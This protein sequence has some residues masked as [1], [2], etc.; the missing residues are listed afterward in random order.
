MIAADR[1]LRNLI[2][3]LTDEVGRSHDWNRLLSVAATTL[4]IGNLAAA[5]LGADPPLDIPPPVKHLL[6]DILSRSRDRNAR[7]QKQLAELLP[8]LNRVG[9]EPIV[10]KGL[11]RL[12]S[13]PR[14]ESRLLSDHDILI[15]PDKEP[16][17]IEALK[18]LGY[19]LVAGGE[20]GITPVFGR[21]C[22]VATIDLHSSLKPYYLGLAYDTIAEHCD[23]AALADGIFLLPNATCQILLMVVHDQ[24]NDRDYWRGVIDVR[25]LVDMDRL[26][27][28]GIDWP[29]LGSF[30][31]RGTSKRA[32]EVQMRTAS[33]LLKV[34]IP[35][36]YCGGFW[37]RI[38]VLRRRAQTRAPL[39]RFLFTPL[40]ILIDPPRASIEQRPRAS[41]RESKIL[42]RVRRRVERYFWV[43]QPGKFC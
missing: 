23:R 16:V 24:L 12:L 42:T 7:M 28:E 40:T 17:A 15:P 20:D 13:D 22:D 6:E 19:E 32:L 26:L 29:L 27:A 5:I 25:H 30:F 43:S 9:I 1:T 14:E 36:E 2:A 8:V 21:S 41:R 34:K 37:P 10:M 33:S 4:T 11:A 31:E 18:Q 35:R 38:Q 39:G 3:C